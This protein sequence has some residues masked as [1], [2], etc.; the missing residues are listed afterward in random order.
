MPR[1]EPTMADLSRIDEEYADEI[2][3]AENDDVETWIDSILS[4][5]GNEDY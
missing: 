3:H 5:L 2:E 1:S 4:D